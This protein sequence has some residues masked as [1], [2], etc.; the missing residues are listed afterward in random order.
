[1]LIETIELKLNI[2]FLVLFLHS[3]SLMFIL[4]VLI[5]FLDDC[6]KSLI[7]TFPSIGINYLFDD[8]YKLLSDHKID[9]ETEQSNSLVGL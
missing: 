3:I 6:V 9:S 5:G 2:L 4:K 1:M 8:S 7:E